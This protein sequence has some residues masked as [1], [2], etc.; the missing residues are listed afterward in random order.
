MRRL[1]WLAAFAVF[2]TPAFAQQAD[3]RIVAE[4]TP[5]RW[6]STAAAERDLSAAA[7]GAP[8]RILSLDTGSGRVE[9]SGGAPLIRALNASPVFR[10]V[11]A[12][13]LEPEA[14]AILAV[15]ATRNGWSAEWVETR[16]GVAPRYDAQAAGQLRAELVDASGRILAAAPLEDPRTIRYEAADA[17]GRLYARRDFVQGEGV[18]YVALPAIDAQTTLRLTATPLAGAASRVFETRLDAAPE[19]LQ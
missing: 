13:P 1:L 4:T 11:Q 6:S 2:A 17:D 12:P 5:G 19:A 15:R 9:L 3:V 8:Y 18:A 10:S 16:D 7:R 14:T